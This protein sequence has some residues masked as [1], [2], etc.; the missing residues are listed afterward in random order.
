MINSS[1]FTE[2]NPNLYQP[3]NDQKARPPLCDANKPNGQVEPDLCVFNNSAEMDITC[4]VT[5]AA[6]C[7]VNSASNIN[8]ENNEILDSQGIDIDQTFAANSGQSTYYNDTSIVISDT[9][10]VVEK[11]DQTIQSDCVTISQSPEQATN[12][13]IDQDQ[14]QISCIWSNINT[15]FDPEEETANFGTRYALENDGKLFDVFTYATIEPKV[16][17]RCT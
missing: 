7:A 8:V 10:S 16:S 17:V 13:T 12:N 2:N 14:G 1:R 9:E 4:D 15:D 6:M 5:M 3:Q 11:R